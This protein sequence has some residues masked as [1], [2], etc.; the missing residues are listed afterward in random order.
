[1]TWSDF[2]LVEINGYRP[3]EADLYF[4]LV[5]SNPIHRGSLLAMFPLV[6]RFRAC[7]GIALSLDGISWSRVTPLIDCAVQG[8]RAVDHPVAGGAVYSKH[9]GVA[10]NATGGGNVSFYIQ[11]RVPGISHDRL[12]PL[13]LWHWRKGMEHE[14]YL[15]RYSL[16]CEKFAQWTLRQIRSL[17]RMPMQRTGLDARR[18]SFT[19]D[20]AAASATPEREDAFYCTPVH[21]AEQDK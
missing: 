14:S 21:S 1:M 4:F 8:E 6:H 10:S 7:V 17:E 11:H 3:S 18:G 15:S 13:E 5:Q 12:T 2:R 16:P 20:L 19:A 9:D